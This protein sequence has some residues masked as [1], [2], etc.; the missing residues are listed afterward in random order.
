METKILK[1]VPG[2]MAVGLLGK[3]LKLLPKGKNFK[4]A[5]TKTFVKTGITNLVGISLIKATAGMIK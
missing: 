1:I 3:N 5:K 4:P 2:V